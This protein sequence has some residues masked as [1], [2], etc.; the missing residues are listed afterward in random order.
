MKI[1]INPGHDPQLDPDTCGN[2][3]R[4][5]DVFLKIGQRVENYLPPSVM[6]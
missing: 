1:F 2:G 6:T 3:L 4:E 5:A